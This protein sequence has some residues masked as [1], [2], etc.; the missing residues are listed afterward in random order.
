MWN[1]NWPFIPI[2]L[3]NKSQQL[4]PAPFPFLYITLFVMVIFL[5]LS[6][7][8]FL[9]R[10]KMLIEESACNVISG[11][12]SNVKAITSREPYWYYKLGWEQCAFSHHTLIVWESK[13]RLRVIVQWPLLFFIIK[14]LLLK[15][16]RL[17]IKLSKVF[18]HKLIYH[19]IC[20]RFGCSMFSHVSNYRWWT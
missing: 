19:F 16:L 17:F 3:S 8:C 1:H 18:I 9:T 4:K 14:L 12:K 2:L 5:S 6:S 10:Q 13:K 11:C 15:M 7:F 20:F